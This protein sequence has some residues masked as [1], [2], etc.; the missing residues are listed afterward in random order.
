MNK[1]FINGLLLVSL[2]A[3]SAGCFTSCKDYDDDI[4]NLQQQIDA[5]NV[6][7]GQLQEELKNGKVITSI[8]E[9]STGISLTLSDGKVLNLTNGKDGANGKDGVNGTS[10]TIGAD[11]YWYENGKKT[12]YRAIG[13]KGEQGAPGTPGAPGADGTDGKDGAPG[14]PGAPGEN[15]KYY[16]PEQ[17]GY[18]WIYQDGKKLENSGIRWQTEATG[19]G[20]PGIS[21]VFSGTK[22]TLGNVQIGTDATGKPIYGTK[23]FDM[24]T[25]VGSIEFIPSVMSSTV[26]Y[27]TTDNPFFHLRNYISEDK[28]NPTTKDF[29]RQTDWNKS[30]I[31]ELAY[32][33]N[34]SNAYVYAYGNASFVGRQ[35]ISRAAGDVDNIL[36]VVT[37]EVTDKDGNKFTK[38]YDIVNGELN[39]KATINA[40]KL[41]SSKENIAAL[42][43]WNGQDRTVSDYIG[44]SSEAITA[45]LVDSAYMKAHPASGPRFFYN[46][47]KALVNAAAETSAF[48]QGFCGL[49]DPA[50]YDMVY[51]QSL[52]LRTLPGLYSTEQSEWISEL[53]FVGMSYEFSLPKEYKS[54]DTQGTNQQWFVQLDGSVL[55]VNKSNLT[56]GLTPAI[57]RTPVVR[58]DAFL[59]DN[60]GSRH[61]VGSAYIKIAIVREA[62]TTPE[63]QGNLD[64]AMTNK[65]PEFEYHSL[66]ASK[67]IVGQMPWTDVNNKI[68]GATGLTSGTF[69][70][71]YGGS[72][73]EYEVKVTVTDLD[74]SQKEIAKGKAV[75]DT[76]F[77]ITADGIFCEATLGKGDTQTSNIKVE[78]NNKAKT[79][80]TY[81][82]VDGKGAEYTVTITIL[83]DNNNARKNVVITQKFYILCK[84]TPF[85][86]NKNYY[87]GDYQN[88]SNVVITKGK[89][90]NGK[91]ALQMNISEVFAMI[92]GKNIFQYYNTINNAQNIK[93]SLLP[94]APAGVAYTEVGNPVTNGTIELTQ[95]LTQPYLVAPM[96][97]DITLVNSEKCDPVYF[98]IYFNNPFVNTK[99][100]ALTL[101]GN[102][103]GAVKVDVRPSVIVNDVDG[104]VIYSWNSAARA[105]QLSSKANNVYKVAA[106]TVTYTFVQDQA[107]NT[108]KGDLDPNATFELE[109]DAAGNFTGNVVYD[110]L[111]ATLIPSYNLTIKATITF[112][113][114]SQVTCEIPF[115]VEGK[116]K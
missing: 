47:T 76:P 95:A 86:F 115:K 54:D 103:T 45:V 56:A 101:N 104:S 102:E 67:T 75:A 1:K 22:L 14:A 46:R 59:T 26:A 68:Y 38:S 79:Q 32:R 12:D 81:K 89:L 97:Y 78:I 15:G 35:V 90:V 105:L 87:A 48:I 69:W 61:L 53:G 6:D 77:N 7:L 42:S 4:D 91:W 83:A 33:V 43:L 88:Y 18:F 16:V 34:P 110:N 92:N 114:L 5:I 107:Y 72:S 66:N 31:V 57:G 25:P 82:N 106:P 85:E 109:K 64:V 2:M 50:N 62:P 99:G 49:G 40:G 55:S 93:F 70:N 73:D 80:H 17:D 36:N 116:N 9:T 11:G 8:S 41:S 37:S 21:A 39:L 96:R 113:D 24:G 44:I 27:P 13:E 3:G 20:T 112:A 98:N 100:A 19:T 29:I 58:V 30:N 63:N 71:N 23:V 28:Y 52:D 84:S 74:G 51:S 65:T 94:G 10:W 111:G 108:F 60:S